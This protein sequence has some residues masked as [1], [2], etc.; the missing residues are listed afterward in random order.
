MCLQSLVA[1]R[2]SFYLLFLISHGGSN[3][4]LIV[5]RLN[6]KGEENHPIMASR[7]HTSLQKAWAWHVHVYVSMIVEKETLSMSKGK[8]TWHVHVQWHS[9]CIKQNT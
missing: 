8:Y 6:A 2:G 9:I 4:S 5:L 1:P 7:Q 3:Q